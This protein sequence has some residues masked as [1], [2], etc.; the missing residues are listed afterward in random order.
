MAV[1]LLLGIVPIPKLRAAILR[2]QQL[3]VG[4]VG[5]SYLYLTS[6]IRGAA[7]ISKV[8]R[9]LKWLAD[10]GCTRIAVVAHSQGAAIAH[11]VVN[12]PD[13]V[14]QDLLLTF[15]AGLNKLLI[16]DQTGGDRTRALRTWLLSLGLLLMGVVT[17]FGAFSFATGAQLYTQFPDVLYIAALGRLVGLNLDDLRWQILIIAAAVYLFVLLVSLTSKEIKGV[18]LQWLIVR[19]FQVTLP[20]LIPL[21]L[22]GAVLLTTSGAGLASFALGCLM[23]SGWMGLESESP[24]PIYLS[25]F[26]AAK[27]MRLKRKVRWVDFYG[28]EDPVSNGPLFL[29][30]E[31]SV[32]SRPVHNTGSVCADHSAY[33]S[34][35]D[36]FVSSVAC[37]L[38][39]LAG[40]NVAGC[41]ENGPARLDRAGRRRAWRVQW[42]RVS[43]WIILASGIVWMW[44]LR[45]PAWTGPSRPGWLV[46]VA[47]FISSNV[48]ALPLIDRLVSA[49]PLNSA[50]T[51]LL[52]FGSWV[53][54]VW[55]AYQLILCVWRW[56]DRVDE[57]ALFG[58]KDFEVFPVPFGVLLFLLVIGAAT[59]LV[60]PWHEVLIRA[61]SSAL[62]TDYRIFT[63]WT[64]WL[65]VA[66]CFGG[67]LA[68]FAVGDVFGNLSGGTLLLFL[69]HLST[70]L[71]FAAVIA[72]FLPPTGWLDPL[73]A[74]AAI[75][76]IFLIL[77]V[78]LHLA[79]RL[80]G[81]LW[82]PY[83]VSG[84]L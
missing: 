53:L 78:V 69:R 82:L 54:G 29:S 42:R 68:E 22:V 40:L 48:A 74:R 46:A 19:S 2:T 52:W 72:L 63:S 51:K 37:E 41:V 47:E 55:L 61:A 73:Y 12:H 36:E 31:P 66:A 57:A 49:P 27:R 11:A 64:F 75:I 15:G 18:P 35:R 84:S 60:A 10:Q 33:W 14:R 26:F 34:N 56:W 28:T 70:A 50:A 76:T 16:L 32:D 62:R 24:A 77:G 13:W 3:L 21:V 7:L 30:A 43:F 8:Q 80:L 1:L 71:P 25:E 59:A 45:G 6:S 65:A 20:C 81:T 83:S 44:E 38:G 23:V 17:G 5:D 67:V 9:D 58:G 4:T 39:R 79:F